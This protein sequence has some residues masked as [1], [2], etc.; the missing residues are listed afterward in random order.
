[1]PSNEQSFLNHPPALEGP[2]VPYKIHNV[3]FIQSHFWRNA[4]FSVIREIPHLSQYAGRYDPTVIPVDNTSQAESAAKSVSAIV[5][6]R[7]G[8]HGYYT[9]ADYHALYSS[10][11]LTPTAVIETLLPL[12]RRDT[13]PPG[14]HSIAFLESQAELIRAAAE[15]STERYKKGKSLGPLDGV[16]VAVKDEVHLTGYK[17]TLG[18][19]LD[20]KHGTDATS[21]CVKQWLDAGAIIIGKTS[22]HEIGLD[23]NNNNPNY[24]TPRNPH[25]KEYYCGGSSG[26][27]G[28]A[29]GAGLVPIALGADGGGSIRIPSSFC[30]IWGLKPSHGR[31]S[32]APS[33]SLAP[34]VGVIGP[35]AASIDDLALAYRIMASPAPP[36]EDPISSQFPY[37]APPHPD[38][39]RTKTIGIVRDWID[40]AEGP[41]RAVLDRALDYYREQGYNVIDIKIPYLPEG[42]R[43]HA[44][45][46]MA[47]IASGVDASKIRQLTAPNKVLVSMGMYQITAQDLLAS[48]R[49]RNLLMTHLAHLFK[50][51]PGMLIVSPTTPIPGWHIDGGEADLSRGLS[52]AKSSVRNMEYVWLANFTGCPA[53]SC[54]AGY[55]PDSG[56]PIGVMAMGEW[57]TEEDLIAF[58]RDGEPILDLPSSGPS[59]EENGTAAAG[60]GLRTPSDA[61][62]WEDIIAQTKESMSK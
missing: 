24:G 15:E 46:I 9:S 31:V 29:V 6:R 56:V 19:K 55:N 57:G 45:T 43:A 26:G 23:T 58:A 8:D 16:P 4:G 38:T 62:V 7:K 12:V 33:Q 35:M 48:Q 27:S 13:Q 61:S 36:S 52:D 21:W 44:L 11:E 59:L 32:G 1:M 17:R 41:V 54:P 3:G 20:F 30:G 42:Q 47:E 49:L 22:M 40:R 10:G 60:K 14:K 50:A 5:D 25:N 53:I 18:S 39:K 51:H 2:K 34:T 28:Y 37:P